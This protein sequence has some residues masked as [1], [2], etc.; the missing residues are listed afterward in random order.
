VWKWP[1]V[2]G[3]RRTGEIEGHRLPALER[4]A[5]ASGERAHEQGQRDRGVGLDRDL[6][7][8]GRE[9]AQLRASSRLEPDAPPKCGTS[10]TIW[11]A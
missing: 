1:A 6:L 2:D 4:R 11:S 8:V 3:H 7:G 5:G 10:V 9:L